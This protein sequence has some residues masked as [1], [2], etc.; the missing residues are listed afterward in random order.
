MIR[1]RRAWLA[2]YRAVCRKLG[3]KTPQHIVN[4]SIDIISKYYEICNL[5]IFQVAKRWKNVTKAGQYLGAKR[6]PKIPRFALSRDC[7]AIQP[8]APNA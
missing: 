7:P 2:A 1:Q 6:E 4:Y 3:I 5:F 8:V